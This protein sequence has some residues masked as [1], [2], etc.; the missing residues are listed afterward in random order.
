MK[1][2]TRS[3]LH[4]IIFNT[5]SANTTNLSK[6]QMTLNRLGIYRLKSNVEMCVFLL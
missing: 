5:L 1:V 4:L 6:I 3:T 2:M